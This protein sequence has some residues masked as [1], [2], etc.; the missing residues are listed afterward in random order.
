M[1]QRL[2]LQKRFLINEKLNKI[3]KLLEM[4][5]SKKIPLLITYTQKLGPCLNI[6]CLTLIGTKSYVTLIV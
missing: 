3:F 4:K 6:D 5:N 2:Y 1:L